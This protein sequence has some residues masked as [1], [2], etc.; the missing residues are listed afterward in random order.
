MGTEELVRRKAGVAAT[1]KKQMEDCRRRLAACKQQAISD[2]QDAAEN[3]ARAQHQDE[4]RA[5][6]RAEATN[7]AAAQVAEEL[8]TTTEALEAAC[9]AEDFEAADSLAEK[10][11]VKGGRQVRVGLKVG[12][13]VGLSS[14]GRQAGRSE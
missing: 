11:V 9:E 8:R 13:H 4:Q 7:Q 12:R 3:E 1:A 5:A 14:T 10:S 6:K 2:R